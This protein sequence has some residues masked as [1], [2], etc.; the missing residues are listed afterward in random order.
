MRKNLLIQSVVSAALLASAAVM[1]AQDGITTQII[2]SGAVSQVGTS[3]NH[4]SMIQM[5]EAVVGATIGSDSVR[6]EYRDNVVLIQ[7]LKSGVKTNL[8]V[9][10]AHTTTSYEIL[11][12]GSTSGL[13]Y[14]LR[15]AFPAPPPPPPGPTPS[16]AQRERDSIHD[17][18]MLTMRNVS[19]PHFKER[20]PGVHLRIEQ[21]GE[22]DY[23]YY[24]R[25]RAINRTAHLYRVE[26]PK[27]NLISPVFG[28]RMALRS[29][30]EQLTEKK[31]RKV[32]MFDSTD[33]PTH[34]SSLVAHDLRPFE[35]TKWVM[36]VKKPDHSRSMYE[37]VLPSDG[38]TPVHSVVVF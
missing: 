24:V 15:E 30:N 35:T 17:A 33:L 22:D 6:M 20:K 21:V 3:L 26:T 29:T 5:P 8:I 1:V 13:S 10:T 36:A 28:A 9:W 2:N 31:F 34:G 16:E 19:A 32:L 37:F 18:F 11:P 7:P 23:S 14:S 25:L 4:V 27:V 38:A 12:A